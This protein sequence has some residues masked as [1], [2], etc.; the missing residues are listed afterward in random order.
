MQSKDN[1]DIDAMSTETQKLISELLERI[2]IFCAK[3]NWVKGY[4]GKRA[5]GDDTV[6]ER[7]ARGKVTAAK[8][9]EIENFMREE[10]AR[11][12]DIQK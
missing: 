12:A 2:G 1:A 7:L 4:F 9:I 5:G 11:D 3:R 6:V 10:E 8:M